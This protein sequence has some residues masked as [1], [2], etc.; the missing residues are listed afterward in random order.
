MIEHST[1]W[2]EKWAN[3]LSSNYFGSKYVADAI[4]YPI[5]NIGVFNTAK[6]FILQ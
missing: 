1:F 5:G 6:L 2:Y 3:L 4:S